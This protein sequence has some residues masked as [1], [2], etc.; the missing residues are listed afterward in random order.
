VGLQARFADVLKS[1]WLFL[2]R[3]LPPNSLIGEVDVVSIVRRTFDYQGWSDILKFFIA[4]LWGFMLDNVPV[5]TRFGAF[6]N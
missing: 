1:T 5:N 6:E 3:H 2:S 4:N